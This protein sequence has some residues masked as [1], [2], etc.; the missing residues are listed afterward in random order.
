MERS[1]MNND[2]SPR[3]ENTQLTDR[4]KRE[5]EYYET[6]VNQ[7]NV[8]D[9]SFDPIEG[10]EQRPW[11]SYW[12]VYEL[13]KKYFNK[14]RNKMLEFGCGCG[15]ASV[16]FAKI[17]FDVTGFDVSEQSLDIANKLVKKYGFEK[18]IDLS[19]QVA[20]KLTY[21]SDYFDIVIGFD[22]LHHVDIEKGIL[23]CNRILKRG[24]IAIF[25]EPVEVPVL[26]SIRN[27][28]LIKFL[29]PNKKSFTLDRHITQDERK[30]NR[31][32]IRTLRNTFNE[33]FEERFTLLSRL[34]LFLRKFYVNKSSPLE[35]FD[36]FI[37]KIIPYTKRLGGD[38]VFILKK[39]DNQQINSE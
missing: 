34:D 4:Q 19:F 14:E 38:A 20:E 8:E 30:L 31:E 11:N 27:T 3:E 17:G 13:A 32:D 16:R 7:T 21:P 26:E 10:K 25:R 5:K 23:E 28:K 39:S 18:Q 9:I 24:G 22:I 15:V 1:H 2:K 37:F 33:M 35:R 12:Y 6:F 29:V 36:H